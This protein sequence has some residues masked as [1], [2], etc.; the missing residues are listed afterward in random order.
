[1]AFLVFFI[2]RCSSVSRAPP[3]NAAGYYPRQPYSRS[4]CHKKTSSGNAIPTTH[5]DIFAI[6]NYCNHSILTSF[7][8]S[9]GVINLPYTLAMVSSLFSSSPTADSSYVRPKA[10][11]KINDTA[12]EVNN[13]TD[14][15]DND[16]WVLR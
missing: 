3:T 13:T 5:L 7:V 9:L 12:D 8:S 10:R 15:L 11:I 16:K 4:V 1:M 14:S 2:V 6:A